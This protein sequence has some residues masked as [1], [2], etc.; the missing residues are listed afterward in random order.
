[1]KYVFIVAFYLINLNFFG[2]TT[3]KAYCDRGTCEH[4]M[5]QFTEA[6]LDWHKAENMGYKNAA[7]MIV[8]NCN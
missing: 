6:C 4:Q 7:E 2:Q 8:N 5:Q 3:S 1:M